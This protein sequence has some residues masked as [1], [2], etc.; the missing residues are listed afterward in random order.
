MAIAAVAGVQARMETTCGKPP[1][2]ELTAS[3]ELAGG[4]S[5]V[6]GKLEI[7]RRAKAMN[8]DPG[9]QVVVRMRREPGIR[10]TA[11]A[12]AA[13]QILG[14]RA[15]V[16]EMALHALS[17][18]IERR[19]DRSEVVGIEGIPRNGQVRTGGNG[20]DFAAQR[21]RGDAVERL[22]LDI[23]TQLKRMASKMRRDGDVDE[24]P[25]PRSVDV[26]RTS[27]N[28]R[29]PQPIA[30]HHVEQRISLGH[31]TGGTTDIRHMVGVHESSDLRRDATCIAG[32]ELSLI[33]HVP[34][35]PFTECKTEWQ[36]YSSATR[37]LTRTLPGL[38]A[39]DRATE[40]DPFGA[41]M[42]PGLARK[43]A[44]YAYAHKNGRPMDP[45][46]PSALENP[47]KRTPGLTRGCRSLREPWR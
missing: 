39:N 3:D 35:R 5:P 19:G 8:E 9:R 34:H 6:L 15:C 46:P 42:S 33:D 16:I 47:F 27:A 26:A 1:P 11:Q 28:I 17:D 10:D 22:E 29:H 20:D 2:I 38:R 7:D 4:D 13:G 12:L 23:G 40:R 18:R 14:E 44:P 32:L 30:A 43:R 45:S 21:P 37:N 41:P 31:H 36:V 24:Q 25:A